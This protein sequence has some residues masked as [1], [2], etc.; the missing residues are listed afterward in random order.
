MKLKTKT[1]VARTLVRRRWPS[2]VSC[3]TEET[4]A[5]S[6]V[7]S[8]NGNCGC[9]HGGSLPSRRASLSAGAG[10][11]RCS[12]SLCRP[13]LEQLPAASGSDSQEFPVCH[14][15]TRH[16]PKS[17]E[18]SLRNIK[19][20]PPPPN[21]FAFM[22]EQVSYKDAGMSAGEGRRALDGARSTRTGVGWGR[23]PD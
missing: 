16:D 22:T 2:E 15:P 3:E 20:P 12:R 1:K 4:A 6:S 11:P 5:L 13:A 14:T 7:K 17:T 18:G 10:R 19:E 23:S 8:R 21:E 9:T